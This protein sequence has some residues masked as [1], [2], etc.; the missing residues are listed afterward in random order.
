MRHLEILSVFE[1]FNSNQYYQALQ[2]VLLQRTHYVSN[3]AQEILRELM[4][5]AHSVFVY[6]G[7]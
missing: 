7:N 5:G 1:C 6:H 2:H 3:L 4:Y